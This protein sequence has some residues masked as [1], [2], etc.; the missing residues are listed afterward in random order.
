MVYWR[1]HEYGHD[2]KLRANP[3][4][5]REYVDITVHEIAKEVV[6]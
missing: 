5:K 1:A 2:V 4:S 6:Y 3:M